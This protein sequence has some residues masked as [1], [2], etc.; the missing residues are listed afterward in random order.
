M[1]LSAGEVLLEGPGDDL[2]LS[3]MVGPVESY[4]ILL[5]LFENFGFDTPDV[6]SVFRQSRQP[7]ERKRA[8]WYRGTNVVVVWYNG[9]NIQ[10]TILSHY[11]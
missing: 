2:P 3:T 9:T 5:Q 8:V 1:M 7:R 10:Y 6:D 4:T 11:A